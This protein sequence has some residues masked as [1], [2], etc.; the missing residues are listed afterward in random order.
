MYKYLC[1]NEIS[2]KGLEKFD[3]NYEITENLEEAQG[4]LVRSASLHGMEFSKELLAV[5]RAG[6]GVNNIPL[7]ACATSG[8]VVF[9]TP[10]ANANSVKELVLCGM[11]LGSRG[12]LGG[13][14]W[15][16][17]NAS[18]EEIAKL[19]EKKKSAFAGNEIAGKTLGIIGMGNIGSRVAKAAIE[20]G[21]EVLGYDPYISVD[22]AWNLPSGIRHIQNIE[23]I[24]RESDF[25]T[26]HMPLLEGTKKTINAKAFDLMKPN[27]VLLNFARDLLVDEEALIAALENDK[28]AGYVT[29]FPN[30]T[31][32]KAPRTII[33]PHIGA[34]T[35]E[36]EDNCAKMAVNE[37]RNYLE[38]GNIINS[39]NYPNCDMGKKKVAC[40][41]T[42]NHQN[43]KNMIG[44][45]TGILTEEDIN[46]ANMV[47]GSRGDIAYSM[48]DVENEPSKEAIQRLNEVE[49]VYRVRVI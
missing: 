37:L 25:I 20:L 6:A 43:V 5:A 45:F 46:I 14:D 28:I 38:N 23:D 44:Q 24:Y 40:R 26:I 22:S 48:F 30:P 47:N 17:E 39:V 10:G 11:L 19:A 1:L 4:I 41:I 42:I 2:N 36:S 27:C 29:D 8:I 33:M 32:V 12:I 15:V 16:K 7:E 9:N 35:E 49:G 3:N 31:V 18:N 13:I 34:S 21:M